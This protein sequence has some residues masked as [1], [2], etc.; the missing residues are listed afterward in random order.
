MVSAFSCI[1]YNADEKRALSLRPRWIRVTR[2][3]GSLS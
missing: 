1:A 3:G 2:A